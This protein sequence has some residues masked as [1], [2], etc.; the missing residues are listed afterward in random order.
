MAPAAKD[1]KFYCHII[2]VGLAHGGGWLSCRSCSS[3][4]GG[5]CCRR[6]CGSLVHVSLSFCSPQTGTEP[7]VG[8]CVM[9]GTFPRRGVKAS[10]TRRVTGSP[11]SAESGCH[12]DDVD[13][14]VRLGRSRL[15]TLLCWL[16]PLLVSV[17]LLELCRLGQEPRPTGLVCPLLCPPC[18]RSSV[19]YLTGA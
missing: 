2:S 12:W 1:L 13:R 9:G 5:G 19:S 6:S 4:D 18:P 16:A 15:A 17:S 8:S 3:G 10:L 14:V 11:K 7:C